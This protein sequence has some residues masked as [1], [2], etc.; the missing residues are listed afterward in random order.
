MKILITGADGMV[1]RATAALCRSRGDD[2]A[3]LTRPELDISN[4]DSVARSFETVRPEAVI[5]C[6]AYTDVDGAE[7]DPAACYAAN[8]A[9]VE[10]LAVACRDHNSVFVTISTD[11]VFE[12]SK[13]GFYTQRDTPAPQGVYAR[14]KRDGEIRAFAAYPRS[15]IVRTGWIFG[16]H[17]RN[18]LSVVPERLAAG[19][20]LTPISDSY[21]T[22]TFAPDLAVRL[23]GL[24]G[25]DLPGAY[26]VVNSG[27][28]CSYLEFAQ[29]VCDAGGFDRSLLK[30]SSYRDL[31]RPAPRPVNSR[32][33][34]VVSERLG[35]EPLRDWRK[36][37]A[38]FVSLQK[39][40]WAAR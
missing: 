12:G 38:E 33:A 2:V 32:L 15:I 37:V 31:D 20:A 40:G 11:Y 6:A 3:A 26:H 24:A 16:E 34:C 5:N 27:D 23:R 21:G 19:A 35:F 8:S 39:K 10:N 9:G 25:D 13:D 1:A 18:F 14:S 17:G 7:S 4:P 36:A 30:P 28:G 22:P 29:E